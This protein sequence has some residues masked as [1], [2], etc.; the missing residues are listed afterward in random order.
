MPLKKIIK[1]TIGWKL[2]NTVLVFLIN[3]LMVRLLGVAQ[4]GNFFYDI[5]VLSFLVLIISWCLEAG[6]TYYA[7]KDNSSVVSMIIFVLPLL[8]IQGFISWVAIG[9]I[10][11]SVSSHLAVLFIV[12]NLTIIYFSAFFYAKKWF[13]S[14]NIIASSISFVITLVL[15]YWWVV[16]PGTVFGHNNFVLAYIA[17]FAVQ[18]V[19]VVSV[20]LYSSKKNKGSFAAIVPVAKNVFAYSTIAFISNVLFFMVI[21]IDYFFVQKYCSNIALGNYV[22][23][24]K[25]GQLL[26]LIPAVIGSIIFPYSAGSNSAMPVGKVQQLCRVITL[27][28][29]PVTITIILTAGWILP[30]VFGQG[31][32]L[33]YMALLLYL[34]GFFSLSII[35]VLAAHLAAKK[36]LKANLLASAIALVVV[37]AGDILLIPVAGINAAAAVSSIAYILCAIYLLWFYK[38]KFNCST[39]DFFSINKEEI[40][41]IFN[42]LK[43]IDY[44]INKITGVEN[45]E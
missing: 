12:S 9:Y 4:S 5:T 27:I 25:F 14:L 41:N 45:K 30:W 33:M 19:L 29:I 37:V 1:H 20:I 34:P 18:A 26:I 39:A 13:I 6:I 7:S 42:H 28:Y 17:S 23:V 44:T 40:A 8:V 24:S 32:N 22:Q 10:H 43:K 38:N 31:F 35:T 16:N 36:L 15:F 21:R 11:L 3:L 2:I